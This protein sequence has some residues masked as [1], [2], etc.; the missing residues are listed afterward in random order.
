MRGPRLATAT[1]AR[2]LLASAREHLPNLARYQVDT[3]MLDR[4]R[5]LS[6]AWRVWRPTGA[7]GPSNPQRCQRNWNVCS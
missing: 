2:G 1:R 3:G 4:L 5:T 6:A 7:S